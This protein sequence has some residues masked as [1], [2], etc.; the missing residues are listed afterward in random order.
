[1]STALTAKQAAVLAYIRDRVAA[2]GYPPT[3]REIGSRFGIGGTNGVLCHLRAL[4]KKGLIR[5]KAG[6]ARAITVV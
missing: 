6:G 1:M 3:I 2:D 5:R 4:E